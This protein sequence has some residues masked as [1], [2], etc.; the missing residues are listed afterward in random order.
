MCVDCRTLN[1]RSL[2]DGYA[3]PRIE[4]VF[5]ILKESKYFSAID[6][7]AGYHQVEIEDTHK[8]RTAFQ[9]GPLGLF[10]YAKMPFGLANSPATYQRPMEECLG[11]YNLTI[12]AIYLND[13]TVFAEL[14]KKTCK[15]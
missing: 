6:M 4:E 14:S 9:V 11:D 1:D 3:L 12:C 7:K 2:K 15:D 10:E 5:D 8:E 13:L